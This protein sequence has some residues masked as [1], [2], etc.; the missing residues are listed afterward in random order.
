MR[1]IDET[2]IRKAGLVPGGHATNHTAVQLFQRLSERHENI[3]ISINHH[4]GKVQGD[5][6][7]Y[8]F[9]GLDKNDCV[10]REIMTKPYTEEE[11]RKI[12]EQFKNGDFS[13]L[14]IQR[15]QLVSD[16]VTKI[17]AADISNMHATY[18]ANIR[19]E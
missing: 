3:E 1:R 7:T 10:L 5:W 16:E 18:C 13:A 8:K 2:D 4:P 15:E 9:V 12:T 19:V 17:N 14:N 11:K 6:K